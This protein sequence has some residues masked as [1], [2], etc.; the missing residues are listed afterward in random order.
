MLPIIQE[1][2]AATD[3]TRIT[4][5]PDLSRFNLDYLDEVTFE[6]IKKR[7]VDVAGTLEGVEV[8]FNGQKIGVGI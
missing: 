3:F 5:T 4:F 8:K 6:L 1:D 2:P 7:T